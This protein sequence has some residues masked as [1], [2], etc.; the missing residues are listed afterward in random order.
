MDALIASRSFM[1]I[2]CCSRKLEVSSVSS[3]AES[4][5]FAFFF[6]FA[7]AFSAFLLGDLSGDFSFF[8]DLLFSG[9]LGLVPELLPADESPFPFLLIQWKCKKLIT[10]EVYTPQKTDLPF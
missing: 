6:A 1:N 2:S 9:D 4:H 8:G 10:G 7:A 5:M 3:T